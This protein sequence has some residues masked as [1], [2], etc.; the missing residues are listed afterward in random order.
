VRT[1][2][3]ALVVAALVVAGCTDDD[4]GPSPTT[5]ATTP[6][7]LADYTGV[8]LPGVGGATTTTI[9]EKGTAR[10]TGTVS[11]PSGFLAGATV[12]IDRLVAGR[13]VRHDVLSGPDGRWELRDVPGGRYRVRA[14]LAPVYAQ[15]KA[16]VKFL[17][18]GDEHTFDL[19]VDDQRGAVVR[20]DVAPDQ[21]LVDGA[22]NL[23][24]LVAQ[25]VVGDDGV[26]RSSPLAGT[27]VELTGLG[28][29]TARDDAGPSPTDDSTSTTLDEGGELDQGAI[30]SSEG[31]AQFELRCVQAGAPGLELRIPVL[32]TPP[33]APASSGSTTTTAAPVPTTEDVALDLPAC[34]DPSAAPTPSTSTP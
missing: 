8:V 9:D 19:K 23:V 27:F 34:V 29:W 3:A 32:V 16:E 33:A 6:T 4:A 13:E 5:E 1:I 28:R 22:V 12:R 17:T 24:V 10:L 18:D 31:R 30:L 7:S 2:A 20:A 15:T 25:R 14:F 26:V 11:G 21:P